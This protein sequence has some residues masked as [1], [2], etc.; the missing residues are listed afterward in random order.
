MTTQ[1]S[2]PSF[3]RDIQPLF[4]ARTT[5]MSARM[6]RP[7]LGASQAGRC[8]ATGSGPRSRS[9]YFAGGS[10]PG[11]LLSAF[12]LRDWYQRGGSDRVELVRH[13]EFLKFLVK[14]GKLP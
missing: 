1:G 7:S 14:T 6:L 10:K 8:R 9:L 5:T 12:R 11:C 3:A 2:T 4:R 13:L